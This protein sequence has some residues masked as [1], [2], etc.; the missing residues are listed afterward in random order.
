[1][2]MNLVA[3]GNYMNSYGPHIC[4]CIC[5][6]K[7]QRLLELLL[8][9][10]QGQ[11]T[12]GLFSY[13][14]IVVDNDHEQSAKSVVTN[15]QGGSVIEIAYYIEDEKNIAR[16]R[17]KAVQNATGDFIA[18]ID[19]DE[20][21]VN[22]WLF[23]LFKTLNDYKADGVLGP[24]LPHFEERPPDWIVKGRFCERPT[25]KTG[26]LLHWTNTRTGN[27]LLNRNIFKD[28]QQAFDP[29]FGTGGEDVYFFK[30][31]HAKGYVFVWCN[32][33]PVYE[34]VPVNRCTKKYFLRRALLQ[35][36]VSLNYHKDTLDFALKT[37]IF[38]KAITA[39]TL[40]TLML[41]F[42]YLAGAHIFMK[43]LIKDMHHVSRFFALLG[44]MTVEKRDF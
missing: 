31:M 2:S 29:S 21:P 39:F 6:Y 26:T 19:D 9:K 10:L 41:P 36:N 25:Y 15:L 37:K 22:D 4:V 40:Y 8:E 27:V 33:A 16:A 34:L 18:F 44:I 11:K 1:M 14:I 32:G 42:V 7:R 13:S 3:K 38:V 43:Y 5:T 30:E 20:F 35:G 24:V 28:R 17:N 12:D 23:N